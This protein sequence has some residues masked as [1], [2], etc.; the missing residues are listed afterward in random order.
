MDL[1]KKNSLAIIIII[2]VVSLLGI[3][4]F[5]LF[6]SQKKSKIATISPMPSTS[7]I[8][9][10][11]KQG[12]THP[13]F[14]PPHPLLS[15]Y[16]VVP[17]WK[18]GY[19]DA[20]TIQFP[21]TWKPNV[22]SVAGGGISAVFQ[23]TEIIGTKLFPRL[24]IEASPQTPTNSIEQRIK[25][26]NILHF[27]QTQTQFQGIPTTIISGTLPFTIPDAHGV[28]NNVYKSFILFL[29]NKKVYTIN[30]A[31]YEDAHVVTNQEIF[32][33]MI[34]AIKLK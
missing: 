28:Q 20:F 29:Y 8:Q 16:Q 18:E 3:S 2:V 5:F 33:I 4:I 19:T 9:S 14:V 26:L 23:P 21:S 11:N 10:K 30:Y 17:A 7:V 22:S 13:I 15:P 31:Y 12:K 1:I 32:D 24:E 27:K 6:S 34:A 25:T